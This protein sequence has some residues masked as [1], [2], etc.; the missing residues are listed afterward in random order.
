MDEIHKMNKI[1]DEKKTQIENELL[2]CNIDF[3]TARN[4][5]LTIFEL[6]EGMYDIFESSNNIKK[7]ELINILFSNLELSGLNLH[8]S[9]QKPF[10]LLQKKE[11]QPVWLPIARTLRTERREEVYSFIKNSHN[12]NIQQTRLIA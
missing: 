5:V 10:E 9:L 8:Y 2:L 3:T 1:L 11:G 7:R 12:Q 6:A 4:A